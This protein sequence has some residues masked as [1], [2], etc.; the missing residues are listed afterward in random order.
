MLGGRVRGARVLDLFAGTGA[1]GLEALSRGAA[2]ATF[3]ESGRPALP[4]LRHNIA[5]VATDPSQ[6]ELWPMPAQRAIER[7]AERGGRFEFAF[8]DPPFDSALLEASLCAL[9]EGDLLAQ[10][11]IVICEH[12]GL[13]EPPACPP[14]TTRLDTRRFGDVALSLFEVERE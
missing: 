10:A 4:T 8:L 1:F 3:V 7:L 6:W 13:A 2:H 12:P 9:L 11:G 5:V 14:R